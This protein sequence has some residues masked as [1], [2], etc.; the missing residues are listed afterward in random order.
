MLSLLLIALAALPQDAGN[1]ASLDA[2]PRAMVEID[3]LRADASFSWSLPLRIVNHTGHGFYIDSLWLDPESSG[4]PRPRV[5][6]QGLVRSLPPIAARDSHAVGLTAPAVIEHGRAILR[7]VGHT[8]DG[9]VH[10]LAVDR[11]VA[12]GEPFDRHPSRRIGPP[13]API[14]IVHVPTPRAGR[15]PGLLLVHDERTSARDLLRTAITL[16]AQGAS[17]MLV[18]L[19]GYGASAGP[20]DHCGPASIR[21]L[22]AALDSLAAQP[23]VDR[24]RLGVWGVSHG[25]TAAL[26]LAA[27]REDVAAV[28]AQSASYDLW[29]E[30]RLAIGTAAAVAIETE[31]GRD[32]AGWRERSPSMAAW[33]A[34]A[35]VL[36]LH[37]DRDDVAPVE[38][39]RRFVAAR[40]QAS[41]A[42]TE[43]VVAGQA[44]Q[45]PR[46]LAQRSALTFLRRTLGLTPP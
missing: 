5:D 24:T 45:L 33:K 37:G 7:I 29:A 11:P 22:R 18:S 17:V 34:K 20:R 30:H 12:G 19:P 25:A 44:H 1:A 35:A 15:V 10:R 14:E 26:L 3:T 32:S 9:A 39:A 21:A 31:A 4:I 8:A 6:M 36:V 16:A 46:G 28:V 13:S 42:T 23:G 27:Q 43:E 38:A 41:L 2:T 40:Q